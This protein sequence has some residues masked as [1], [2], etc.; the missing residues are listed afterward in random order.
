[1]LQR[2]IKIE[3]DFTAA[4]LELVK[5]YGGNE[6]GKLLKRIVAMNSKNAD[7]RV[8]YGNWLLQRSEFKTK[9]KKSFI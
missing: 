8:Q 6:A 5:I 1:M 3:P 2:C 4:Y 9:K 7:L